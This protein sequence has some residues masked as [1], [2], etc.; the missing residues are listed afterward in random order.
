MLRGTKSQVGGPAKLLN[1]LGGHTVPLIHLLQY[2]HLVGL[3]DGH[4]VE[5]C[6]CLS[7][8][9]VGLTDQ[10]RGGPTWLGRK[11]RAGLPRGGGIR[12]EVRSYRVDRASCLLDWRTS[13]DA[14]PKSSESEAT[15]YKISS[16][17]K[18][19]ASRASGL[20]A[21]QP[22]ENDWRI[23][24]VTPRRWRERKWKLLTLHGLELHLRT[25]GRGFTEEGGLR[26]MR[27]GR[28][29]DSRSKTASLT[30]RVLFIKFSQYLQWI[31]VILY[32]LQTIVTPG[33][34]FTVESYAALSY[35]CKR[36]AEYI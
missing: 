28:T 10:S 23:C 8:H 32:G 24:V 11:D 36:T 33:G 17:P 1:S 15:V 29:A 25:P 27:R 30:C 21:R 13:S 19:T 34:V 9:H 16:N 14:A 31:G 22:R 12:R 3:K 5:S 7:R 26:S 35:L 18:E 4:S 6:T 20:G 2:L